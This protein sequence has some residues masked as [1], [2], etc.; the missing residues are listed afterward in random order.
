MALLL[1]LIT[2]LTAATCSRVVYLNNRPDNYEK[3]P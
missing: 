3:N 2:L 1:L